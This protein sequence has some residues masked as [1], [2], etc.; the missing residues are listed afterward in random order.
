MAVDGAGGTP[1]SAPDLIW[2]DV[3]AH[4]LA[5]GSVVLV[6]AEAG[7]SIGIWQALVDWV[8]A[9]GPDYHC[10]QTGA[11]GPT[12]AVPPAAEIFE[13]RSR[14]LKPHLLC[15]SGWIGPGIRAWLAFPEFTPVWSAAS[16]TGIRS[17][18]ELDAFTHAIAALGRHLGH[19][20]CVVHEW[21]IRAA[22]PILRYDPVTHVVSRP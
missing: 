8:S 5:D 6:Y 17:Q 16:Q 7:G 20:L 19:G 3:A 12:L 2:T 14:L 11:T 21:D 1:A 22:G 9:R 13:R 18:T 4:F 10:T 15:L